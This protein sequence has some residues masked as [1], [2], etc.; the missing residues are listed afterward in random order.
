MFTEDPLLNGHMRVFCDLVVD[1]KIIP[2]WY[3]F[4]MGKKP[5]D[6][7]T[8]AW[9]EFTAKL[10]LNKGNLCNNLQETGLT[11]TVVDCTLDFLA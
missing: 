2:S 6:D 7:M 9:K 11:L 4:L 8:N 1:A 3:G 5:A 10:D